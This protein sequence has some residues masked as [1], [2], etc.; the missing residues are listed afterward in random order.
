MCIKIRLSKRDGHKKNSPV[1]YFREG[2][3]FLFE[4]KT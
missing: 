1:G 2:V 3:D 4:F